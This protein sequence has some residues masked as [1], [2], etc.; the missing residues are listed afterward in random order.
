MKIF[1]YQIFASVAE[2]GSF[3]KTALALNITPSAVS[4]AIANMENELGFPLLIRNR[5]EMVLS[6]GGNELLPI[7]ER[8]LNEDRQ[9]HSRAAKLAGLAGGTVR[10]GAISSVCIAW[11]PSIIRH[12]KKRYPEV[13][14]T[15]FQGSFKEIE[16]GVALGRLDLGFSAYPASNRVESTFLIDDEIKCLTQR[17]FVP[18]NGHSIAQADLTNQHFI[19]QRADYDS[20]TKAT[21]DELDVKPQAINYSIDDQSIL[22]MVEAG[23]GWGI[24]PDLA[25][26]RLSGEVRAFPFEKHYFRHLGLLTNPSSSTDP[27]VQAMKEEILTTITEL[28]Q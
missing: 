21:L 2:T 11:L 5:S 7:V 3:K 26:T 19:L 13:N 4:H 22:A 18:K 28:M 14:I 10:I 27:L 6:Q 23:L 1:T 25:L 8:L 24:L 20:D 12:F 15:V 16:Q 9:I 17:D